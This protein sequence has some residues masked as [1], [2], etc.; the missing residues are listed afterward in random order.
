M[1]VDM[2]NPPKRPSPSNKEDDE[3]LKKPVRPNIKR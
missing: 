3:N 1:G 2:P